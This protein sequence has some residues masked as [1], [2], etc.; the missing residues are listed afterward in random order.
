MVL[1]RADRRVVD[2]RAARFSAVARDCVRNRRRA[3]AAG[4]E[5]MQPAQLLNWAQSLG[6]FM[7]RHVFIIAFA[8]LTLFF[9]YDHGESIAHELRRV[10]RERLGEREEAYLQLATCALRASVNSM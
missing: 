2:S 8:I 6:Q 3:F 7:G 1:R 10:L 5:R 9:L 4:V